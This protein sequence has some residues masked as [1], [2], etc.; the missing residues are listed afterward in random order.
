MP[1]FTVA[2]LPALQWVKT[3]SQFLRRSAPYSPILR[4]TSISLSCSSKAFSLSAALTASAPSPLCKRAVLFISSAA[5]KR[6]TA[7]GREEV[8]YSRFSR[9]CSISVFSSADL[10]RAVKTDSPIAAKTPIAGAPRTARRFIASYISSFSQS[11]SVTIS[12]G[13]KVWSIITA[14]SS[15]SL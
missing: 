6:F 4:H 14:V 8:R 5:A 13:S 12:P 1:Y 10:S 15:F 2:S 11:S 9:K 7:V 3:L